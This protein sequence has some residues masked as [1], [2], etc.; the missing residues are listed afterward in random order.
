MNNKFTVTKTQVS[1]NN[2]A[3]EAQKRVEHY[4]KLA[5]ELQGVCLDIDQWQKGQNFNSKLIEQSHNIAEKLETNI[6]AQGLGWTKYFRAYEKNHDLTIIGLHTE[7]AE[8]IPPFRNISFIPFVARKKRNSKAKEVEYFLQKNPNARAWTMTTGRKC[9]IEELPKRL[10]KLHGKF[11]RVNHQPFMKKHGASFV[12]RSTEF[13]EI[14]QTDNGLLFHPHAHSILC[15]DKKLDNQA[16]CNLVSSIRKYFTHHSKD[17]GVIKSAKELVKYCVKPS[18][19]E[20]LDGRELLSIHEVT[21]KF[22]L[23]EFLGRLRIQRQHHCQSDK[24]LV[25][26]KG[27][28]RLTN[29]WN[30]SKP[31]LPDDKKPFHDHLAVRPTIVAWC[32]PMAMFQPVTE[33]CFVVHGL[34]NEDP[35][36]ILQSKEVQTMRSLIKVHTKTLTHH[37]QNKKYNQH[38]ENHATT[39]KTN[40]QS[41]R[42]PISGKISHA[43]V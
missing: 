21:T 1:L 4:P 9:T 20:H 22:R 19:L 8:K 11:G 3:N 40:L 10:E 43:I 31:R 7:Q 41:E 13:G 2:L 18:D 17:C 27:V 14:A 37:T 16:W 34:G 36:T 26:R 15:L 30:V 12:F 42:I 24:K 5:S 33:P 39:I 25:R 23:V 29:N 28:L 35:Q 32:P 6:L 38:H